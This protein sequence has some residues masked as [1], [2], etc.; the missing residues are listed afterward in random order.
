MKN[1]LHTFSSTTIASFCWGLLLMASPSLNAQLMLKG[2]V[3]DSISQQGISYANVIVS[4]YGSTEIIAF[5]TTNM[6]GYY[7]LSIPS[8]AANIF[9]ITARSLGYKSQEIDLVVAESQM[10]EIAIPRIQLSSSD[11]NLA[12][13]VVRASSPILVKGDTVIYDIPHWTEAGNETLEDVLANIPGF[14]IRA[15]GEISVNGTKVDKVVINGE[16]LG[17]NGAAMITRSISAENVAKVSLRLDEKNAKIKES[18]LDTDAYVVLDITLKEDLDQS[19]FGRGMVTWGVADNLQP[20]GYINALSLNK[21]KKFHLF[22]ESDRFGNE[23]IPLSSIRNLGDE[24][25]RSMFTNYTSL[26]EMKKK[27]GYEIET[28]NFDNFYTRKDNHIIGFSTRLDISEELSL[29]AGSY[30]NLNKTALENNTSAEVLGFGLFAYNREDNLANIRSFNKLDL[31]LDTEKLKAKFNVHFSIAKEDLENEL[32]ANTLSSEN[33]HYQ[34]RKKPLNLITHYESEKIFSKKLALKTILNYSYTQLE[35]DRM[36]RSNDLAYAD[37]F[38]APTDNTNFHQSVEAKEQQGLAE[39]SLFYSLNENGRFIFG[40]QGGRTTLT[41]Q[42]EAFLHDE[43][44]A[45]TNLVAAFNLQEEK[46]D[47]LYLLP[48]VQYKQRFVKAKLNLDTRLGWKDIRYLR[49]PAA[50]AEDRSALEVK[51]RLTFTPARMTTLSL[52]YSSS[53]AP[54]PY[55]KLFSGKELVG[56]QIVNTA[57][58]NTLRPQR[59]K[60]IQA[61]FSHAFGHNDAILDISFLRGENWINDAYLPLGSIIFERAYDQL[62]SEYNIIATAF[63]KNAFNKK[64]ALVFEPELITAS[65]SNRTEDLRINQNFVRDLRF[66][67][68]LSTKLGDEKIDFFAKPKIVNIRY[69]SEG[70]IL[71]TTQSMFWLNFGF[72]SALF[73]KKVFLQSDIKSV[74]FLNS[75]NFNNP[76]QWNISMKYTNPRATISLSILNIL[77]RNQFIRNEQDVFQTLNQI[78]ELFPRFVQL[79]YALKI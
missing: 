51:A 77:N 5:N 71:E 30:S 55:G 20:G 64:L 40:G 37:Y 17:D 79:G 29:Y 13:V 72:K 78:Q 1:M 21:K 44:T 35:S 67:I 28:Y 26:E 41:K 31:R 70:E 47:F 65:I 58:L 36:L 45:T 27:D 60:I 8:Q 52:D 9:K 50:V 34:E 15:N 39:I 14:V 53:L 57:G 2:T 54:T 56:F 63:T 32:M 61:D 43:A 18:L 6:D 16:E 22:A 62:A 69:W 49:N 10:Q 25:Y 76:V 48:F 38:G 66:G 12:T 46:N 59:D 19:L 42:R 4:V 75:Q 74:S 24:A 73:A 23:F 33:T 68:D 3:V 11:N 7:E